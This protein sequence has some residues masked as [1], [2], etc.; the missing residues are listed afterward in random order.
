[1]SSTKR[2]PDYTVLPSQAQAR[3][4]PS[5]SPDTFTVLPAALSLPHTTV[6]GLPRSVVAGVPAEFTIYPADHFGNRG[7]KGARHLQPACSSLTFVCDSTV[8]T[9]PGQAHSHGG[10]KEPAGCCCSKTQVV[11]AWVYRHHNL[12]G[13]IGSCSPSVLRHAGG[14][15]VAGL[16]SGGQTVAVAL[17]E[18]L[19]ANRMTTGTI[20]ATKAGTWGLGVYVQTGDNR[21]AAALYCVLLCTGWNTHAPASIQGSLAKT[22]CL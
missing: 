9:Y 14:R 10:Q 8:L 2:C 6:R 15:F 11:S 19:D 13:C 5:Q 18:A 21:C 3:I 20:V 12:L 1:M 22:R 7:A 4:P 16:I 17:Q